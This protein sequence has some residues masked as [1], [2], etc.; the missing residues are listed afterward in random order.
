MLAYYLIFLAHGDEG[1]DLFCHP[2]D[3]FDGD[4]CHVDHADQVLRLRRARLKPVLFVHNVLKQQ[5]H[6]TTTFTPLK[7]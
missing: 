6:G 3:P 1:G 2:D 5:H 7:V 4:V